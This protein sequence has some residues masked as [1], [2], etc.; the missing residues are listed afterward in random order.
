ML[1]TRSLTCR[2]GQGQGSRSPGRARARGPGLAHKRLRAC[3]R[4]VQAPGGMIVPALSDLRLRAI[5]LTLAHLQGSPGARSWASDLLARGILRSSPA[6][7]PAG[8]G[9]G[10]RSRG[11]R[12]PLQLPGQGAVTLQCIVQGQGERA[13]S[14][15]P[16][17][18]GLANTFYVFC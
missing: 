1:T 8:P 7:S 14:W 12:S 10:P 13:G 16:Q 6:R 3:S 11:P 9:L 17:L 15:A 4:P 2:Q 5:T 18:P